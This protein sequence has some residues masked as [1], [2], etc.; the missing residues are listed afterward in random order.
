MQRFCAGARRAGF[1]N[2]LHGD[3]KDEIAH[4]VGGDAL[5]AAQLGNRVR[6]AIQICHVR[7]QVR[8]EFCV[9]TI[10]QLLAPYLEVKEPAQI[11]APGQ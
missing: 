7:Q 6:A 11:I 3:V 10:A 1:D 8:V 5:I 2:A 4:A 9:K